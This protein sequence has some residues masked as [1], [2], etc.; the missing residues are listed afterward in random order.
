MN[1][2]I[3]VDKPQGMTSHGVVLRLRSILRISRTGHLGTLDPMATGVLPVCL[4]QATRLAQFLPSIPKE[5]AGAMRLGFATTTY[6]REGA[7]TSPETPFHG[8]GSDVADAAR[9]FTGTIDQ[10]PP[11]YSAKRVD[12]KRSYKL[13]R[14]GKV[15]EHQPSRVQVET[16]EITGFEQDTAAFRVVCSAGTYVRSLAHDVGQLLGCGAHLVSLRRLRSG[17]FSLDQARPLEE[18]SPA[19]VIPMEALLG[20]W[21]RLDVSGED[22]TRVGHGNPV[23]CSIDAP[24]TRIFNKKGEFIAIGKIESGWAHPRVVLTSS[25]QVRSSELKAEA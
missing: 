15:V 10:V 11:P 19:D 9:R 16:F 4:G 25:P 1:G 14:R 17:P 5:Y 12:G 6:D 21:P 23:G 24:A 18:I 22:E 2:V 20:D 3:V 7:P 13:A 8:S